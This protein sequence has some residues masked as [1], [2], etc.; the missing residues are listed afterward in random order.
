MTLA[1]ICNLDF[2]NGKTITK[3]ALCK[4]GNYM[5]EADKSFKGFPTQGVTP[6]SKRIREVGW[7]DYYGTNNYEGYR[8][9]EQKQINKFIKGKK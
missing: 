8:E 1:V 2:P 3:E 7:D 4:C 6:E 5:E 9:K